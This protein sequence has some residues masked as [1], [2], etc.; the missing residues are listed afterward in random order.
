M[1]VKKKEEKKEL[2]ACAIHNLEFY[3]YCKDCEEALCTDCAMFGKKHKGHEFQHISKVYEN[4]VEQIK[5][6]AKLLKGRINTIMGKLSSV[7][8]NIQQITE[9]KETK[10]NELG[11]ILEQV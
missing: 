4:Q 6:E 7:D 3:Y 11:L 1:S 9:S 8:Q 5:G 10:A 2:D